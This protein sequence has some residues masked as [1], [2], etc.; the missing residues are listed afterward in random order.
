MEVEGGNWTRDEGGKWTPSPQDEGAFLLEGERI[1]ELVR[2]N[3]TLHNGDDVP[4]DGV[5]I[6]VGR[7]QAE[8]GTY[9][10]CTRVAYKPPEGIDAIDIQED[11]WETEFQVAWKAS[12]KWEKK[13]KRAA[14]GGGYDA[15]GSHS[16]DGSPRSRR[17]G[18]DK[19]DGAFLPGDRVDSRAR[20]AASSRRSRTPCRSAAGGARPSC[21]GRP[22]RGRRPRCT[23]SSST[24]APPRARARR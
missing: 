5:V 6:G 13:L 18:R 11:L 16:R 2:T 20:A 19:T 1:G 3:V 21:M 17:P 8:D 23:R 22:R 15:G 14:R 10:A 4:C 9:Q 12:R 24:P 7:V